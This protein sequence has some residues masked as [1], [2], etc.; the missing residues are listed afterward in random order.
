MTETRVALVSGGSRGIGAAT[1][2]RLAQDGFDVSFCYRSASE[3]AAQV[4]K[5]A[6]DLGARVFPVQAD[7]SSA[8]EVRAWVARAE[9]EL[10]PAA[11]VVSSAG[12]TRDGPLV[13]MDGAAWN[14]VVRTNLD[15]TCNLC[16]AVVLG[17]MKRR[18][19]SIVTISSVSGVYGN[20]GQ[21]NYS[22]AK[23]GIIG[24]TLALAKEVGRRGVR[25]NVVV[26]GLIETGMISTLT[27]AMRQRLEGAISLQRFGR[28]EEVADLVSFLISDR[29]SYIT[30]SVVEIHGGIAI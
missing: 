13:L 17:M 16:R 8:D 30:G 28:P 18:S 1:V 27:E 12:I 19:G 22:A 20:A 6:C 11:V 23:A 26:P 14:D 2:L 24:F 29:A 10:G 3:P 7:V 21:T 15:G 4:A 9:E 5:Q 25:A